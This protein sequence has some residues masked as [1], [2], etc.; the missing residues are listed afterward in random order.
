MDEAQYLARR[1]AVI[2]KGLIVAEGPPATL[3]GRDT[4]QTVIRFRVDDGS[5]LPALG[6]VT[7][8]DG[9]LELRTEHP[10]KVLHELT[11][12]ALDRGAELDGL[13]VHRPTLEDVYLELTGG[14]AGGE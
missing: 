10:T 4:A 14:E 1:V 8:G 7:L 12:W 11:A 6:Q 5:G 9:T 13:E 3:A 2:A